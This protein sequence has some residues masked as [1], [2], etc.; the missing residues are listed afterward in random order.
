VAIVVLKAGQTVT[1][2]ELRSFAGEFLARYKLPSRLETDGR[3]LS[4]W[5]FRLA[6][7]GLYPLARVAA[8]ESGRR[9]GWCGADGVI[10]RRQR[11]G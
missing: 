2:D 10:D 4:L 3:T 9:L 7:S 5:H 8:E 11:R 6:G 1:L